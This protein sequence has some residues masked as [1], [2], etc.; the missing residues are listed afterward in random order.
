M[1]VKL[2]AAD[3][4]SADQLAAWTEIQRCEP[5]LD[6]PYF[7]P[8]FTRAVAAVR[9][10]VEVGVLEQGGE[11][12]GFFPFQRGSGGAALPVG[13][14]MSDFHGLIAR[15]DLH[16]QPSELLRG[17]RLS[18]WRFDH[19][20]ASQAPLR[21]YQWRVA[22][23]PYI[24]LSRGWEAYRNELLSANPAWMKQMERKRRQAERRIGPLRVELDCDDPAVF[25]RMLKW[26]E[27]KY[28]QTGATNV[29]AFDW[30][31]ALLERTRAAKGEGF[32]GVTS[33]LYMGDMLAAVLFSIRSYG[34][35]HSWFSAYCP[36]LHRFSPGI[37]A[38]LEF[39]RAYAEIGVRRIDLGKG[40]EE[41]KVRLMSGGIDVAEGAL[42]L[43]PLARFLRRN[44]RR[45]YDWTRRSPL[46]RLLL[47]PGRSIRRMIEARSF[48]Q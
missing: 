9:D 2:L 40:P 21:P 27:E 32:S 41:Y 42:D 5:A 26:K 44:C 31:A 29:L 46:R 20:I 48:S 43:R 16:W 33:A 10:D 24:D 8:E 36:D 6:S 12:V 28:L 25:N 7:R 35:L 3:K 19:L 4:L 39:S 1:N 23:S 11:P 17:C 37:L 22:P 15:K 38:W 18:A 34:V 47:K 30:T 14:K 13:G 45:A